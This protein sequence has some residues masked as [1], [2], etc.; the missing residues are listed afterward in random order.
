MWTLAHRLAGSAEGLVRGPQH[1]VCVAQ[2]GV[3][4]PRS[5]IA[6][7]GPSAPKRAFT[8]S[9]RSLRSH[10]R[11]VQPQPSPR[12]H[13]QF[14]PAPILGPPLRSSPASS[15][16]S[17]TGTLGAMQCCTAALPVAGVTFAA[18][19]CRPPPQLGA[20]PLRV[21]PVHGRR[22]TAPV[23]A[24]Q[25]A[26]APAATPPPAAA[27]A[28]KPKE[29]DHVPLVLEELKAKKRVCIAQTAPAVRIAIGE[30]LGLGPGVNATG[31]MVSKAQ[32]GGR[33]ARPRRQQSSAAGDC[34]CP[35][36]L[37]GI[38]ASCSS[39]I[40]TCTLVACCVPACPP[41]PHAA[42]HEPPTAAARC[43]AA[44]G[45]AAPPGL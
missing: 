26:E 44:G 4:Q 2:H 36:S 31:K 9:T 8:T 29:V 41:A 7:V 40:S 5:E 39:L 24:F 14:L 22:L 25:T 19:T 15:H 1:A 17:P 18:L 35:C 10:S 32:A 30:D 33:R 38:P 6:G 45:R 37:H 27:A 42:L 12:R 20:A 23:R 28:D 34:A 13:S 16:I 3:T 11:P 21:R 43:A